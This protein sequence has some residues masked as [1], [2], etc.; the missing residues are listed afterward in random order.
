MTTDKIKS[1][2]GDYLWSFWQNQHNVEQ[3]QRA[4]KLL[5][6]EIEIGLRR[7]N[8]DFAEHELL[9]SKLGIQPNLNLQ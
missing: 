7:R 1:A 4:E 9:C 8:Q 6:Y 3:I 5:R 2:I